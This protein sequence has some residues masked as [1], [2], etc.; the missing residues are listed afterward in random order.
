M[1]NRNVNFDIVI[2]EKVYAGKKFFS[3][4]NFKNYLIDTCK[5]LEYNIIDIEKWVKDG[6]IV[7]ETL[8]MYCISKEEAIEECKNYVIDK[9]IKNYDDINKLLIEEQEICFYKLKNPNPKLEVSIF[10]YRNPDNY[11]F[12]YG[13]G[14]VARRIVK[15]YIDEYIKDYFRKEKEELEKRFK[16]K[17][18]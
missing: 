12:V 14:I 2:S 18:H 4:N 7:K 1:I 16:E 10:D 5:K 11:V 17:L 6:P 9:I 13:N 15:D 8:K 3:K